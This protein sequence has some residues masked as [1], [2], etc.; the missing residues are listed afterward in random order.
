MVNDVSQDRLRQLAAHRN[1]C[2]LS[3]F[4]DLDP[5]KVPTAPARQSA[6]DAMLH[7][8]RR[9]VEDGTLDHD[10]RA[11]MRDA[12]TEIEGRLEP[13]AIPVE[14]ARALAIFAPSKVSVAPAPVPH[15]AV[16]VTGPPAFGFVVSMP[17]GVPPPV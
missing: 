7:E 6:V 13:T 14:G 4:L 12:L 1:G 5:S 11:R 17:P 16:T 9:A 10:A 3:L 2:V 15:E 8:A